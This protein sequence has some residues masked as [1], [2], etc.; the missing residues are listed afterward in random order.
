M[1]IEADFRA[2]LA[3]H[4]PLTALVGTRI[5]LNAAPEGAVMPLVVFSSSHDRTLG[6]D[7]SLLAD[8]AELAVQ[9]WAETAA[10]AESVADAVTA[11]VA[12]APVARA[13]AS[14]AAPPPSTRRR[15]RR[16]GPRR[17][18][19]GLSAAAHPKFRHRPVAGLFLAQP[20]KESEMS[21]VKGRGVRVEIAATYGSP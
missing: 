18:V 15:A 10:A 9:C 12:T 5:A 11:A 19:V 3:A 8:R 4:A 1:S 17:G 16:R 13:P 20:P 14:P 21:N 2:T 6:L 7:N